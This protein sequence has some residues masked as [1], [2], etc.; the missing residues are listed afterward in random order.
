VQA[1]LDVHDTPESRLRA[2]L[3]GALWIDQLVPFQ[4]SANA[5]SMPEP[6]DP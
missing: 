4:L 2:P 5:T 3:V 1:V 6:V